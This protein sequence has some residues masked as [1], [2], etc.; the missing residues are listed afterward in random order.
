MFKMTHMRVPI[1]FS[2]GSVYAKYINQFP[3]FFLT[4]KVSYE[5]QSQN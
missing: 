2:R 4:L 5:K 1:F 3:G